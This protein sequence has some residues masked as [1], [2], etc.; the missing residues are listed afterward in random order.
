MRLL[1]SISALNFGDAT[2]RL[3]SIIFEQTGE[4]PKKHTYPLVC[5]SGALRLCSSREVN[6]KRRVLADGS[7]HMASASGLQSFRF[8][9]RG[10]CNHRVEEQ[11]DLHELVLALVNVLHS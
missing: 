11:I 2:R 8:F 7:A 5:V 1:P 9:L 3:W 4:M 10:T 6:E